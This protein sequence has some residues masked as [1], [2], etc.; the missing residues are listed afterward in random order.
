MQ[1]SYLKVSA[2]ISSF[3]TVVEHLMIRRGSLGWKI[4]YEEEH[5]LCKMYICNNKLR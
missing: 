2:V 3:S 5:K 4:K 1:S